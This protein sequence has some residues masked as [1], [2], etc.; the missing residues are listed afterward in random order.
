[1]F[2]QS[3]FVAR[4]RARTCVCVDSHPH[5]H[6]HKVTPHPPPLTHTHTHT[7]ICVH[8]QGL[9]GSRGCGKGNIINGLSGGGP[10][11]FTIDPPLAPGMTL[12]QQNGCISGAP[13]ARISLE[14]VTHT[15]ACV[16]ECVSVRE[17]MCVCAYVCVCVCVHVHVRVCVCIC[18]CECA[19]MCVC[20]LVCVRVSS[21][22]N[23]SI[24]SRISLYHHTYG[25]VIFIITHMDES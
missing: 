15:G 13:K 23:S 20:V 12:N 8:A 5:T 4:V 9:P 22:H 11:N 21:A 18:V 2:Y 1:M 14:P 24:S 3:P 16:C 7:R 10:W 17:C 6:T 19:C 25:S